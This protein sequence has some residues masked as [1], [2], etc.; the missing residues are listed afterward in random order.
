MLHSIVL[1]QKSYWGVGAGD[2][3]DPAGDELAGATG[4]SGDGNC[5]AAGEA[6][7]VG[8]GAA[9]SSS[10]DCSTERVP[11]IPGKESV[12]AINMNA[13]AAPIV[14]FASRLAVPRGPNAVLERLLEKRAPAS[15]FPG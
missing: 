5:V 15:A 1:T 13:A 6:C 14:I 4:T 9:S 2:A 3:A 12:K 8:A 11:V 7:C 10:V